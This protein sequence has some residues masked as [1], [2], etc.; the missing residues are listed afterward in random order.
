[1][2]EDAGTTILI[3]HRDTHFAFLRKL[4]PGDLLWLDQPDGR[5][6]RYVV[7]E[8][9]IVDSKTG[10]IGSDG[11]P[12]LALVPVIHSTLIVSGSPWRFV[13][14]AEKEDTETL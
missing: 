5:T 8:T 11:V 14:V 12:R 3:G 6:V 13:A 2:T 9:A 7:R 10:V 1:M 4:R